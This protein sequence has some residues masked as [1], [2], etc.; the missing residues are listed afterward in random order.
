MKQI[1][2][3]IQDLERALSVLDSMYTRHKRNSTLERLL[4]EKYVSRLEKQ[5]EELLEK[6]K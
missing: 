4:M 2:S 5:L 1:T 3:L 6:V